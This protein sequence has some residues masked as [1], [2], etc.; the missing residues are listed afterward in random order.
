MIERTP[1]D[2]GPGL[3]ER[4]LQSRLAGAHRQLE[5][6]IPHE[7]LHEQLAR[8][9]EEWRPQAEREVRETL[10]LEAVAQ[11]QGLEVDDGEIDAHLAEVAAEQ[12]GPDVAQLR[13]AYEER[14][15]IEGLRAQ[16]LER[17]ALAWLCAEAKVEEVP[18]G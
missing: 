16:L 8:W 18:E 5:A 6:S 7:R 12:A 17:K 10:L 13:K 2:L 9:R 1:F 14:N 3:I 4:Q 15:L 11:H